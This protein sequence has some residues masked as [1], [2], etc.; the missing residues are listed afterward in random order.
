MK[1]LAVVLPLLACA[2]GAKGQGRCPE[3]PVCLTTPKCQYD[4]ARGCDVCQC[5]E[6]M[7]DR[8]NEPAPGQPPFPR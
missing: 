7:I 1:W 2:H 5:G 6:A 8:G 4:A 3:K